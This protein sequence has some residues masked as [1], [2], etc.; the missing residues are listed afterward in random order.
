[1]FVYSSS[2]ESS[3]ENDNERTQDSVQ[4][5]LQQP[6]DDAGSDSES[7]YAVGAKGGELPR[8]AWMDASSQDSSIADAR[9]QSIRD[10]I[11]VRYYVHD[12]HFCILFIHVKCHRSLILNLLKRHHASRG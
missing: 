12:Q 3:S 7:Q 9:V 8:P 4:N 6:V 5:D 10:I 11:R 1:M 2:C